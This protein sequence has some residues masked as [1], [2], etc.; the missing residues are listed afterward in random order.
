MTQNE[1]WP[2]AAV[3]MLLITLLL[4]RWGGAQLRSPARTTR[5]FESRA[6]LETQAQAAEAAGRDGEARLIRFRLERGDFREGDRVIATIRGPGGFS[7][8]L[9]VRSGNQLELPQLPALPLNGVL[10]SELQ[11][12]LSTYL[13]QY[14]R[15]PSVQVRPLLRVGILGHL[16]HPGYYYTSADLP[17]SDVLMMAGGPAPEADLNKVSIRR[18]TQTILDEAATRA[19]LSAGTS[20]DMLHMQAGDE[21]QVGQQRQINWPIVVSSATGL[22]GVLFAVFYR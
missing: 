20:M 21:I 16:V 2:S 14:L 22:I 10:R 15:D 7:D 18:G 13:S 12:K 8:T 9:I 5:D 4:P 19:A 1:R 17:L 3:A 6:E 11:P